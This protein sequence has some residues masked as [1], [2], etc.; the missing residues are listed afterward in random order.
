MT[1]ALYIIGYHDDEDRTEYVVEVHGFKSR[2]EAI[3]EK[4][5][6]FGKDGVWT[7]CDVYCKI[8]QNHSGVIL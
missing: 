2:D 5:R 1:Y 7:G 3:A 8:I 6:L 4:R